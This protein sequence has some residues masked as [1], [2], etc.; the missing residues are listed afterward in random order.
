VKP[1]LAAARESRP[2]VRAA[3]LALAPSIEHADEQAVRAALREALEASS[4][5]VV[6]YAVEALGSMGEASDLKR[7]A[8]LVEHADGRIAAAATNAASDLAV[9]HVDAARALLHDARAGGD[10]LALGCVLLGAIAATQPMGHEDVRLLEQALAHDRPRVRRAAV[11]ALAQAG[12]DSAADAVA[13]AVA[14]EEPEVQLAAVRALGRLGCADPLVD[15]VSSTRD[16]VLTATAL[17][18]LGEADAERALASARLLVTHSDPAMACAA[19]EAIGHLGSAEA[20]GVSGRPPAHVVTA[21]EDALFAA[22]DHPDAEVVKLALSMIGTEPGPRALARL[23]LCLDHSA[24]EVRRLAAELLGQ[25]KSPGA[26]ALL[27]ARY[28]REKDPI[29]RDAIGS[30]VSLRPP[31]DPSRGVERSES[32]AAYRGSKEGK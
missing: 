18:A 28:D 30:A 20:F 17:R 29:V 11:E 6:S 21:C 2:S 1:L 32:H 31:A 27:R 16:A 5:E 26:R 12:G 4:V 3:A 7:V 14:D 24:W 25:D 23:G 8:A 9:R 10:P 19:V 15:L 22:L 13:F